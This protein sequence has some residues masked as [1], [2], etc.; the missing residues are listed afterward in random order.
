MHN[1]SHPENGKEEQV[2]NPVLQA[3]LTTLRDA[4]SSNNK[5]AKSLNCNAAYIQGYINGDFPGDLITFER[6]LVDFFANESR[7]RASGVETV[8]CDNTRQIRAAFELIRKTNDFGTLVAL[9]G[10]GKSRGIQWYVRENPLTILFRTT[11]WSSDKKAVEAAMLEAVGRAGYDQQTRYSIF[12][13]NKLRGSDR[14][15][16]VDDA[17]KLTRRAL[18][19]FYDFHEET[20]CP[21]C[22]VGTPELINKLE[23]DAQRFSRT[24]LYEEIKHVDAKGNIIPDRAFIKNMVKQLAEGVNGD[25]EALCDLAEQVAVQHGL[26]RSVHKQLKLA[27]EIKSGKRGLSWPEAFRAAHTKLIRNFKLS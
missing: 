18:Q 6:K 17:H 10:E 16:I 5:L 19:W 15:I 9:S 26:Y 27:A 25:T 14:F 13:V 2:I 4:G 8:E 23:D 21:M 11:V 3:Q 12:M 1:A 20:Q 24:G 7:R 22:L